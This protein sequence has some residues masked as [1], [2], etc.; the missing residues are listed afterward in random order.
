MQVLQQLRRGV[1]LKEAEAGETRQRHRIPI[2][3]EL[4]PYEI[5]MDDI[6]LRKFTLKEVL[7]I[8]FYIQA[9]NFEFS[10]GNRYVDEFYFGESMV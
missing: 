7:V 6:R 9:V 1:K 10:R 4:T 8:H 3:Y 2:E 5:L